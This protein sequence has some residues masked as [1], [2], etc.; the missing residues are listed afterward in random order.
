MSPIGTR[1]RRGPSRFEAG[2]GRAHRVR[3]S[4]RPVGRAGTAAP[5]GRARPRSR[6]SPAAPSRAVG[7]RPPAARGPAARRSR[8]R[9]AGSAAGPTAATPTAATAP[10]R[11]ASD[12]L[13]TTSRARTSA[14]G[15][16]SASPRRTPRSSRTA[17]SNPTAVVVGEP[18]NTSIPIVS[19]TALVDSTLT[20]Q[21]GSWSGRQPI[22]FAYAW[23]RCNAAGGECAAIAGA[24]GRSYRLTSA[25]VDHKLRVNVTA[26]NAIGRT[27]VLSSESGVVG[28][29]LP[30]GAIRLPGGRISIPVT[31][32]PGRPAPRRLAGRLHP[33]SGREPPAL[34]TVR[35]L[36][37]DTRGYVVRDALRLR[38][39]DAEGDERQSPG[40]GDGRP[41]SRP[42][43]PARDVPLHKQGHVQFFVKAYRSGDP[44]SR[45]SAPR[46]A[47]CRCAPRTSETRRG[48]AWPRLLQPVA[49]LR[50]ARTKP[51]S[52][53]RPRRGRA[54]R[55]SDPSRR[56][57]TAR[58]S[59]VGRGSA[60]GGASAI[61][62]RAHASTS[63]RFSTT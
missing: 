14:S 61:W 47:W 57:D 29:P 21:P 35:V 63:R 33:E 7:S 15:C 46:I 2:T 10:S 16:A 44:P 25:D 59:R 5:A 28:V 34:I 56:Q 4:A 62:S 30:P 49:E 6:S 40:D 3:R 50:R 55:R 27:T 11:A 1:T 60:P 43:R 42:A 58:H 23:L 9:S 48:R 22:T 20:V 51:R 39:L 52:R 54:A 38:P 12:G 13:G 36:V 19:G 17:A 18:V 8:S 41:D 45:K 24:T 32:V 26:R 31:S 53:A 37:K